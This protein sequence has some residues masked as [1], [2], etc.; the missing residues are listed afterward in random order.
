MLDGACGPSSPPP[1][2]STALL[3]V[4]P[5]TAAAPTIALTAMVSARVAPAA[6]TVLARQLKRSAPTA[7]WHCQPVP[8]GVSSRV[9]PGGRRS[10]TS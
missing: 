5:L 3:T 6:I 2:T 4:P 7:P 1:S 10:C 8:V 9:S